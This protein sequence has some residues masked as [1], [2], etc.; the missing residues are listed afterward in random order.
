VSSGLLGEDV[1]ALKIAKETMS[2]LT[3]GTKASELERRPGKK[4]K[5]VLAIVVARLTSFELFHSYLVLAHE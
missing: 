5:G 4:N 1:V 3:L 2:F